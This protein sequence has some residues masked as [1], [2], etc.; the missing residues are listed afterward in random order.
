MR[1]RILT[2]V[3]ACFGLMLGCTPMQAQ[4]TSQNCSMSTITPT[5][6]TTINGCSSQQQP[7]TAASYTNV[8]TFQVSCV[9][10][11]GTISPPPHSTTSTKTD[12][13]M[14]MGACI[15]GMMGSTNCQPVVA[16]TAGPQASSVPGN[17]MVEVMVTNMMAV[18][19]ATQ[20]GYGIYSCSTGPTANNFDQCAATACACSGEPQPAELRPLPIQKYQPSEVQ[21][22]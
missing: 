3:S 7:Y 14:G 12:T 8:Y 13:Y 4:Q 17:N 16:A 2:I 6:P 20:Y 21:G 22:Y 15:G 10:N 11:G 5:M 1:V 19:M 9:T 18:A